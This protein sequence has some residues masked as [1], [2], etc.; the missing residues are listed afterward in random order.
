MNL[1]SAQ[2]E[3]LLDSY[4]CELVFLACEVFEIGSNLPTGSRDILAPL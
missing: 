3:T 4:W 2:G 1:A